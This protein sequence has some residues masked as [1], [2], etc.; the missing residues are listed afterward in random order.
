MSPN[1]LSMDSRA[2][3]SATTC[4]CHNTNAI[5][6]HAL[7]SVSGMSFWCFMTSLCMVAKVLP[8]PHSPTIFDIKLCTFRPFVSKLS[9]IVT[10]L[11]KKGSGSSCHKTASHGK[12]AS[13]P[14]LMGMDRAQASEIQSFRSHT[15]VL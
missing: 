13:W 5:S 3:W 11:P 14:S 10:V 12:R 7:R 4:T 8:G 9:G 6:K 15:E 1:I 2:H